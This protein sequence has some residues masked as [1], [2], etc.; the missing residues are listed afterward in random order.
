MSWRD[1]DC[2]YEGVGHIVDAFKDKLP[3]KGHVWNENED[4][5]FNKKCYECPLYY[6]DE[7]AAEEDSCY[8]KGTYNA[9]D[10]L[11]CGEE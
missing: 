3:C 10:K 7:W 5:N 9:I 2:I 1:A 6:Y 11:E 8:I 4:K